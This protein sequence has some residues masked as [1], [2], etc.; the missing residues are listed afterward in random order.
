MD[1]EIFESI[2]RALREASA[3]NDNGAIRLTFV[4]TKKDD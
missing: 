3:A 2:V 1:E 4:V